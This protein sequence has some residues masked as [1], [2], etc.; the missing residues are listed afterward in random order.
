MICGVFPSAI[1]DTD[2]KKGPVHGH[3]L[4]PPRE[5]GVLATMVLFRRFKGHAGLLGQSW[6]GYGLPGP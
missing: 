5:C 3:G 6:G 2:C 4:G 1:C